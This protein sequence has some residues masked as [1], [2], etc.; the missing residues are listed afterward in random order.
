M[1]VCPPPP[2]PL[3]ALVQGLL[4]PAYH[5]SYWMGL[6][7]GPELQWPEFRWLSPETPGPASPY[8]H[9]GF[10]AEGPEPNQPGS[11]C[12]LA[13][14]ATAR[15]SPTGWGWGDAACEDPHFFVCKVAQPQ[16]APAYT[17]SGTNVTF[18]LN[19]TLVTFAE[20]E[21][22]CQMNGGH[23]A[24]YSSIEEQVGG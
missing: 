14:G 24:S 8:L 18:L 13:V 17:T 2:P 1:H 21:E 16:A 19:T 10:P 3:P 11:G 4:I 5:N 23:L 7:I 9:W 15:G 6:R 22:S 20:A 12:A